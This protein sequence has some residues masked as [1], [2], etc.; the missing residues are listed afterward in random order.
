[1]QAE[2][3]PLSQVPKFLQRL[4]QLSAAMPEDVPVEL[5]I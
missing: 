1:L 3:G 5:N 4:A 2:Y